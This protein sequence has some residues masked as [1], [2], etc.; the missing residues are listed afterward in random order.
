MGE[1]GGKRV[2]HWIAKNAQPWGEWYVLVQTEF[3]LCFAPRKR[4][5]PSHE[6]HIRTNPSKKTYFNPFFF[7]LAVLGQAGIS[8]T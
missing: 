2:F 5:H 7:P 4:N 8:E 6:V 1:L 3:A